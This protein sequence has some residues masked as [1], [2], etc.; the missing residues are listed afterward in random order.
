M[1]NLFNKLN[2]TEDI[3]KFIQATAADP[4]KQARENSNIEYKEAHQKFTNTN[5]IGKDVSAFANSEG[6]LIFYGVKC[7]PSDPTKPQ[8][9]MGLEPKNIETFDRVVNSHIHYPIQGIQK[10]L[11]PND[12]PKV[13]LVYVFSQSEALLSSGACVGI[14]CPIEY[15]I[16][17]HYFG[18]GIH[19]FAGHKPT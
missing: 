10:K 7:D 19:R 5:E 1:L 17:H 14:Q 2:S 13:M 18:E 8:T 9:I 6:G 4:E 3:E 11:V 12:S 15:N 16:S